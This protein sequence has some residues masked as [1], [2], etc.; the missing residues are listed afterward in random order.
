[1]RFLDGKGIDRVAGHAIMPT[2]EGDLFTLEQA[3]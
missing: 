2:G 3:L 1:M